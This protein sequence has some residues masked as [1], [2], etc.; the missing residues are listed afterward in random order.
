[1]NS[2]DSESS[3][4]DLA[5]MLR[6]G[7]S[8]AHRQTE[9]ARFFK[10]LLGNQVGRDVYAQLLLRLHPVYRAIEN[11]FEQHRHDPRI[12][13]L[14]RPELHRS[15]ALEQDLR[16]FLDPDATPQTPS[17][18]AARYAGRITQVA[19]EDPALLIAHA[20]TRYLGDLSGGQVVARRLRSAFDLDSNR[21]L[22]FYEFPA[23]TDA[24]AYKQEYRR[25]LSALPFDQPTKQR[26][27]DE[28]NLAFRLNREIA[29]EL[30]EE[31][32]VP[33]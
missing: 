15:R 12:A 1:M 3:S 27:V 24:D 33:A 5:A 8:V 17:R 18:A 22:A 30:S 25:T 10:A 19:A 2:P 31:F 23:V 9:S 16:F 14:H 32:L 7:T 11:A 29:E 13:P 6:H 28:A 26:I 21:G 20:Y 4:H